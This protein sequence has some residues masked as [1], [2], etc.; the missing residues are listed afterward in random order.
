MSLESFLGACFEISQP[1][2]IVGPPGIGKTERTK[3]WANGLGADLWLYH[4]SAMEHSDIVGVPREHLLEGVP[5]ANRRRTEFQPPSWLPLKGDKVERPVVVFL[6][7]FTNIQRDTQ[8]AVFPLLLDRCLP[9]G[10]PLHERAFLVAAGNRIEDGATGIEFEALLSRFAIFRMA[11]PPSNEWCRWANRHGVDPRIVGFILA[12]PD[13]LNT[14]DPGHAEQLNPYACPRTVALV[15]SLMGA[16]LDPELSARTTCGEGWAAE[17]VA[18]LSFDFD[19]R[20]ALNDP[21]RFPVPSEPGQKYFAAVSIGYEWARRGD[22]PSLDALARYVRRLGP[23]AAIISC[24]AAR[25]GSIQRLGD[26]MEESEHMK[27]LWDEYEMDDIMRA[28]S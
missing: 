6:D 1:A 2:L 4:V 5:E 23:E 17:F 27:A 16:G 21:D 3:E 20:E 12:R 26:A 9:D 25:Q 10:R 28:T 14:Y 24:R 19:A 11:S 8:A 18:F 7:D 13:R 22:T 15:S